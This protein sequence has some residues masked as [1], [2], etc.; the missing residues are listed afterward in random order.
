MAVA[1]GTGMSV[2]VGVAAGGTAD[3]AVGVAVGGTAGVAVGV[4]VGGTADVAVG[5][6]FDTKWSVIALN[7]GDRL[8][9]VVPS[10]RLY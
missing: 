5:A 6:T 2:A 1:V 4:A 9:S 10:V 3:V 7:I 8:A